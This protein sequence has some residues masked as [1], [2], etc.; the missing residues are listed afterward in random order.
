MSIRDFILPQPKTAAVEAFGTTVTVSEMGAL[1]RM[2][3]ID[4]LHGLKKR[5]VSDL[6]AEPLLMAFMAVKCLTDEGARVF[7]DNEVETVANGRYKIEDLKKVFDAAAVL[8]G[9]RT[10]DADEPA[11]NA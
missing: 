6:E 11:K 8:N 5:G 1:D 10:E 3:Y 9:L 4:Y 2:Q 7:A